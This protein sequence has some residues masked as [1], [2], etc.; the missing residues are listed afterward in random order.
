M[1]I[2][3]SK[4]V[5]A[6]ILG[7]SLLLIL[8]VVAVYVLNA[9]ISLPMPAWKTGDWFEIKVST[10]HGRLVAMPSEK[11]AWGR[12]VI[13]HF[14]I[15]E[16]NTK[17]GLPCYVVKESFREKT[18]QIPTGILYLRLDN[19]ML[20]KRDLL[21]GHDEDYGESPTMDETLGYIPQFP[22]TNDERTIQ[23]ITLDDM[24]KHPVQRSPELSHYFQRVKYEILPWAGI[25]VRFDTFSP[26]KEGWSRQYICR[27]VP[28]QLWWAQ[29]WQLGG[30]VGYR[31]ALYA[32]SRDGILNYP[33]PQAAIG[34]KILER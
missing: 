12:Q 2:S 3:R 4:I 5:R 14:Q 31:A 26:E 16:V 9:T 29:C 6:G 34:G 25:L 17:A 8:S 19:L 1:R 32:T 27:W 11:C 22:I 28:G 10:W 18:E 7:L 13:Y 33:L 24:K 23:T 30:M 21:N 15:R 20:I